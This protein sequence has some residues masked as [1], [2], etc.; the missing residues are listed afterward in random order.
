VRTAGWAIVD[1]MT[2]QPWGLGDFRLLDRD[3]YYLRIT[4]HDA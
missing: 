1:E 2:I 4:Q 3:G